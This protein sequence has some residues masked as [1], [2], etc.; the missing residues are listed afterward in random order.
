[1]ITPVSRR[2]LFVM[3]AAASIAW[4]GA[5]AAKPTSFVVHLSG[6]QQV[7]PV[8]TAGTGT[9]H[10]TYDAATRVMRWTIT[11]SGL[12]SAATM[13]HFHFGAE[14]KNGPVEIWLTKRGKPVSSPI[15][16]QA[17]LSKVEVKHLMS[18]DWYINLHTKK[19]PAGELRGQVVPPKG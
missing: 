11:Y 6:A 9:A 3:A 18:D 13:A 7:P 15:T 5:A 17:T 10:L 8:K 2:A 19:H 4:A 1:M 12:S 14:G 16:G